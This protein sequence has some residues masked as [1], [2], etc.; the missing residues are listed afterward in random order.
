MQAI[1]QFL[2][3]RVI[4]WFSG[5]TAADFARILTW[6]KVADNSGGSPGDGSGPAKSVTLQNRIRDTWT[7]L[8]PAII[9]WLAKTAVALVRKQG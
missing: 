2:L 7:R 8:S 3:Q 6:V 5:L 1:Y 9:E 4:A